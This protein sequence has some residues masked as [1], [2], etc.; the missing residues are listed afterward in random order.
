MVYLCTHTHTHTHTHALY[1]Y[2]HTVEYYSTIEKDEIISFAATRMDLGAIT[3][4]S[5][6]RQ[7][8]RCFMIPVTCEV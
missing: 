4:I 2:I 1:V 3:L 6:I 5:E 8:K 7:R